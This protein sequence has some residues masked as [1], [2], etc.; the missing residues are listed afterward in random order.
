MDNNL[1]ENFSPIDAIYLSKSFCEMMTSQSC[2]CDS[3]VIKS[4]DK[5]IL[6]NYFNRDDDGYIEWDNLPSFDTDTYPYEI[7]LS[8]NV[9]KFDRVS[10][11]ENGFVEGVRFTADDVFL[12]IFGSEHN[13]ILTMSKYDLFEDIKMDL[14]K[15]EAVLQIISRK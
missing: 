13:L 14:P 12:F 10:Y 2:D 8:N 7:N 4:G 1:I 9:F 11:S 3:I 15:T 5:Y 6:L